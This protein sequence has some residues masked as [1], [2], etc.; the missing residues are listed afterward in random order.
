MLDHQADP[1]SHPDPRPNH[2]PNPGPRSGPGRLSRRR[3]LTA[4][5]AVT[6][7]GAVVV[8]SGRARY[9]FAAE[10]GTASGDVF[11]ILFNRGGIDGLN[12]VAPYR[13]PSYQA[14]RPTLR[15]R[16]PEEFD[17]PTG[18][19]GLPLDAGGAVPGFEHSGVFGLHPGMEPLH[20][21]PWADGRLAVV[22][23]VGLPAS[24]SATRSHFDAQ[25]HW[26]VGSANM[27]LSDGFANRWLA[28]GGASD[29]LAGVGRGTTLQASMRGPAPA[30]AMGS[31]G[32]FGVTGFANNAAA[33]QTLTALYAG[34][35]DLVGVTGSEALAA[36]N[37]IAGL[38]PA[39]PPANGAAYPNTGLGSTL[40]E[41]A[42]LIRAGVGLRVVAVDDGGWDTHNN[43]GVPGEEGSYLRNRL[44][45]QSSALAA[46]Y[47]DLGTQMDSVTVATISEFGRTI[48][49]NSSA[50]TDHG[51]ASAMFVMGGNV[52]GGVYGP[53]PG[54]VANGPE[55]DLAVLTD[56][57]AVLHEVLSV[58][59]GIDPD[60]VFPGLAAPT[61]LGLVS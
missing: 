32:G 39:Q 18:V 59:G 9:A 47:R 5:A 27:G 2:R 22:H 21:G 36:V 19:A 42:Q 33:R 26:E 14:L 17:D 8:S 15:V 48:A 20:Q 41:V 31:I 1:N 38:P 57:R 10:P 44:G 35:E 4:S 52:N 51:R 23:A 55:R 61:P 13:M 12:V 16:P 30:V 60:G 6:A 11:V 49:E 45:Q 28:L 7:A 24:E 54:A 58:R 37:Q 25:R 3:F 46:F 29:P 43:Q 50:G 53:F 56:Y 34:A 40:R